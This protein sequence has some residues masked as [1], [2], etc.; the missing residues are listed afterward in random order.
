[1]VAFR[2]KLLSAI[3]FSMILSLGM[4]TTA[5]AAVSG[6]PLRNA[7]EATGAKLEKVSVNA[8][9][10]LPSG[11]LSDDQL[12]DIVQ[13]V[14]S[15]LGVISQEYQLIHQREK[16]GK[17]VQAEVTSKN[18]H[19]LVMTR[20]VPGAMSHLEP[21]GYLVINIEANNKENISISSMEEKI[22]RITNNFGHSPHINTC[23]IGWLDGKLGAG[24]WH[25]SLSDAF[26]VIDA[27][28]IDKLEDQHYA[29]Y[30][31]FTPQIP[32]ALQVGGAKVNLNMAIRYSQY[33]HRTYVTI[34]SPMINREY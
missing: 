25:K 32:E 33:D 6:E 23:L 28:I 31:G 8:W 20:V 27:I 26:R 5:P 21:D 22:V 15:Q 10:K 14:M 19:V 9:V 2:Y 13:Q 34:A 30:T 4:L 12:E 29:S 7:M 11:Q 1:M 18:L 24:E 3:I 17:I 16:E